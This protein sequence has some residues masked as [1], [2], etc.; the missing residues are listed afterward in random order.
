MGCTG[1]MGRGEGRL[2][3]VFSCRAEDEPGGSGFGGEE[4]VVNSLLSWCVH[5]ECLLVLEAGVIGCTGERKLRGDDL[6]DIPGMGSERKGRLLLFYYTAGD[7]TGGLDLEE[8]REEWVES[9]EK[10]AR[11]D[12]E[13]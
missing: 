8:K 7:E 5:R 4:G 2:Q 12:T 6:H 11:E 13:F 1:D 10:Q 9:R 3:Q